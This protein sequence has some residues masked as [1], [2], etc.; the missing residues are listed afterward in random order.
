MPGNELADEAAKQATKIAGTGR[1]VSLASSK[2]LV[3]KC[4][5]L[6]PPE[7]DR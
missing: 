4:I 7:H 1:E 2:A 3:R 6:P 5:S